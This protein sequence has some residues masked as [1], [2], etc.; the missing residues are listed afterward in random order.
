MV[1]GSYWL[2]QFVIRVGLSPLPMIA[3][4]MLIIILLAGV[5]VANAMHIARSNPV[6]YLRQE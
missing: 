2:E 1:I 3:G 6:E 4:L 5:V